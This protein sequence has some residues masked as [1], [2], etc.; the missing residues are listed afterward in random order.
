MELN[1]D[2][3]R[4]LVMPY[5]E[6]EKIIPEGER[7]FVLIMTHSHETDEQVAGLLAGKRIRYL[8]VLGSS[9]KIARLKANLAERLPAETLWGIHGPIGLPIHSHTPA[10]IAVSV[11]AELIQILNTPP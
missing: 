1:H 8:G 7:I 5:R 6:L 9:G 4:K 3:Q 11:A 10:E 2:A